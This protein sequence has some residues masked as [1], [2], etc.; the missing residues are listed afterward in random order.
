MSAAPAG[1][2]GRSALLR[3][4]LAPYRRRVM[5]AMVATVLST[6][7]KLVPPYLAGLVV[8]DV[9]KTGST[10]TLVLIAIA[11]VVTLAV[12]W[13]AGTAETWLVGD[14]GQRALMDLR[15][16]LVEHLQTLPMS[17]YD[18][19][20]AG[21]VMSRVTNDVEALNNIVTGGLNQLVSNVLLVAG[22]VVVLLVLDWRMALVAAFVFPLVVM[23]AAAFQ[24][25]AG[26]AW[27]KASDA[28]AQV[29]TYMAEGLSGRA[30]VRAFG[31]EER[32]LADFERHNAESQL[33]VMRSNAIWRTIL[34]IVELIIA[35][36]I[37][38]VLVYGAREAVGGAIAVGLIVSFTAY[39]RQAL[40]PLPR[41]TVLVGDFQQAATALEKLDEILA[42]PPDPGQ[43]P[44]RRPAA[45]LRGDVAF[46][47]IRFA[48]EADRWIIDDV[49]VSIEAGQSVAF[50][51]RSGSGKSTLIKLAVGF[52]APQR[53]CVRYDGVDLAQLDPA[54]VRRQIALVAQE[55]FLFAGSVAHNIAWARPG[56][57]VDDVRAAAEAVDALEVFERLPGGLDTEVGERGERLSGGQRQL[58]ALARAIIID[59]RILILDEATSSIDVATEARV[60]RGLARLLAGRTA[61]VI[62]HRVSTIRGAD[63]VV[64]LDGG[65]I[66][67]QG[68]PAD[69]RAAGGH[70]AQLE[71]ES[72][73]MV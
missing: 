49:N 14:V 15:L 28:L 48:Y 30:V 42:E 2:G 6:A 58:V 7:A 21:R 66:V 4:L 50:I 5:A 19:A 41:L 10:R 24:R 71:A 72:E 60:Q 8:D 65:R 59:P 33:R 62:A 32:H 51:G 27:R 23:V 17:Y 56:A 61:L 57:G 37:A 47:N 25:L 68:P 46:E 11:L 29:T 34:P 73:R 16:R 64:V 3:A 54:S 13:L 67:E 18:R 63:R 53:G 38:A 26:P 55:P 20:S 39:L 43:L 45:A 44:G 69:L 31:Q 40:A 12:A 52:Y 35:V 22:T 1:T 36:T 70:Y 9:V